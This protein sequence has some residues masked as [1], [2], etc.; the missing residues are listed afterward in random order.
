[1]SPSQPHFKPRL[2]VGLSQVDAMVLSDTSDD[3]IQVVDLAVN[4]TFPFKFQD[5]WLTTYS[6]G[7]HI[8]CVIHY[9]VIVL[10]RS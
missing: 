6:I 2:Y 1:M 4:T 5:H 3:G 10:E 9:H 7:P 8:Q